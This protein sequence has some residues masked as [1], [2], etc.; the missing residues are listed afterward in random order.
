MKLTRSLLCTFIL[1][2]ETH[3]FP[4]LWEKYATH[5]KWQGDEGLMLGFT[6]GII[7]IATAIITGLFWG[8]Y[9]TTKPNQ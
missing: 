5:F 3:L 1:L 8:E 7:W 2:I 6:Y 9:F 4:I